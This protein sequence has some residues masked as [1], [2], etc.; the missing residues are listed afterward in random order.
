ML[1]L[2][3]QFPTQSMDTAADRRSRVVYHGQYCLLLDRVLR[4]SEGSGGR[5]RLGDP[6]RRS[7]LS[8][9]ETEALASK[10]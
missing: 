1:A 3:A 2:S 7:D 4:S 5:K 10:L 8:K 9:P 6:T